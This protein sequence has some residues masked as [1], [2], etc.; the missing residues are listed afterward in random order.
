[1]KRAL[2]ITIAEAAKLSGL[3]RYAI[4][5]AIAA[6]GFSTISEQRAV[7]WRIPLLP[8]LRSLK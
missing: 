5:K 1:M 7:Y 6:G 2:T 4:R 8:F 3:S